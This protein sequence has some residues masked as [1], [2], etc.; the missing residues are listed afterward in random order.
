MYF[1][2]CQEPHLGPLGDLQESYLC[3]MQSARTNQAMF[4]LRHTLAM[5]GS[6]NVRL[7]LSCYQLLLFGFSRVMFDSSF[8]I[9]V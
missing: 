2:E 5:V 8:H 9:F 6:K 7:N 4:R 1:W 3:A